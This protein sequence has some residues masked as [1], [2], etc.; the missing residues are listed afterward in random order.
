MQNSLLE[1]FGLQGNI[2]DYS[3]GDLNSFKSQ[4]ARLSKK[5]FFF[6][7]DFQTVNFYYLAVEMKRKLVYNLLETA[8]SFYYRKCIF[9]SRK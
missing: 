8:G 6:I 9:R 7:L 3:F 4:I 1:L 2:D 5:K